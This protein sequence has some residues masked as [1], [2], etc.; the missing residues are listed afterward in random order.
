MRT[1]LMVVDQ[2]LETMSHVHGRGFVH[3]DISPSN[4]MLGP[5]RDRIYLIDFGQAKR[6]LVKMVPA[7]RSNSGFFQLALLSHTHKMD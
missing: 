3:R 2:T 4:F 1:L 7:T 6:P 5:T